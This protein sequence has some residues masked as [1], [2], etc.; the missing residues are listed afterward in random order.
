MYQ[1][2]EPFVNSHTIAHTGK[3]IQKKNL[4]IAGVPNVPVTIAELMS[5][6]ILL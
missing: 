5:V 6:L 2:L 4:C 1:V 3:S